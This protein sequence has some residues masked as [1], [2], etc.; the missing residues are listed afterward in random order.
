M[1]IGQDIDRK[2]D[3]MEQ[4]IQEDP[5]RYEPEPNPWTDIHFSGDLKTDPGIPYHVATTPHLIVGDSSINVNTVNNTGYWYHASSGS[6]GSFN[7]GP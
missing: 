2:L 7:T 3:L 4:R 6:S 5:E 1:N